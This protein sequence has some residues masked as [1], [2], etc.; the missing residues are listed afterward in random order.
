MFDM[1]GTLIDT[2]GLIAEHMASAFALAGLAA[3]AQADV[4]RIIGLSLP[5]AIGQLAATED[6]VLID[7]LVTS[8]KQNYRNA[9]ARETGREEFYPGAREAVERLHGAA[10]NLLGIA[11]GK[12]LTGVNRILAQHAIADRFVTLQTPDHNPSKPHPGMLLRAMSETGAAPHEVVMV[13]DT[14]FDME[15]AR[16]AGAWAI[17]VGWGYH[18]RQD[19]IGAGAHI[20]IDSFAEIDDS[21]AELLGRHDA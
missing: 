11:T 1:D 9:L 2:Y 16:A 10:G 14:S 6:A 8:Y 21:I 12:G 18:E 20:I 17:G 15:L 3:P 13:G 4:R 7:G 19:L 5:V